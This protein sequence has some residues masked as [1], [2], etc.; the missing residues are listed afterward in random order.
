[1]MYRKFTADALFTG[2][3]FLTGGEVLV[4]DEYGKII[5]I[6]SGSGISDADHFN[7]TLSPGFINAHC[8]LELSWMKDLIPRKTGM[9]DFLIGVMKMPR[10]PANEINSAIADAEQ[11]MLNSGII[12]VGDIC[13][14]SLTVPRKK[15]GNIFYHNFIEAMGFVDSFADQRFDQAAISCLAYITRNMCRKTNFSWKEPEIFTG[16]SR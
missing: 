7:G 2:Y 12:A 1:M 8:H 5:E 10:L 14:T 9:I 15:D 11:Q 16:S 6:V 13:N 3:E 4:T